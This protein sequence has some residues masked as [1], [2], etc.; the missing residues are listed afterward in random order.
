LTKKG[1]ATHSGKLFQHIIL[2]LRFHFTWSRD[3]HAII[4]PRQGDGSSDNAIDPGH[5]I[6]HGAGQVKVR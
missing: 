5:D 1:L 2:E 3:I 6:I 4:M